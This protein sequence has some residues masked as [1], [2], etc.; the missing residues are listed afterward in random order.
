MCKYIAHK[1]KNHKRG[2]SGGSAKRNAPISGL[3][4][5]NGRINL[6]IPVPRIPRLLGNLHRLGSNNSIYPG[7]LPLD[8]PIIGQKV[9]CSTGSTNGVVPVN[10][11]TL[12]NNYASMLT[13]FKEYCV[14]GA[15]F[16]VTILDN[17]VSTGNPSG[18][19]LV[20]MDETSS[21]SSSLSDGSN[22]PHL[23]L[24]MNSSNGQL[25]SVII[26]WKPNDLR[27]LDWQTLTSFTPA[28]LKIFSGTGTFTNP[29][30]TCGF[31]ITGA[32]SVCL[33]GLN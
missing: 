26:S 22:R 11:Q 17:S 18:W 5:Q 25:R 29:T 30:Q 12:L 16:E 10:I 7:C 1:K 27:D 31:G 14:T 2:S 3:T 19:A 33:R 8:I 13:F 23:E 21:G 6:N 24:M 28:W 20:Y 15:T 4:V 32:L 9:V